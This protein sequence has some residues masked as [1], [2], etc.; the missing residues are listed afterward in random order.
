MEGI[1]M[2]TNK[3]LIIKFQ[4]GRT[5]DRSAWYTILEDHARKVLAEMLSTR[6]CNTIRITIKFR[7]TSLNNRGAAGTAQSHKFNKKTIGTKSKHFDICLLPSMTLWGC[8]NVLTHELAHVAQ[9]AT[10]RLT[11]VYHKTTRTQYHYWRPIDH[12]GASQKYPNWRTNV[13]KENGKKKFKTETLELPWADRPWEIEAMEMERKYEHIRKESFKSYKK[14]V[15][16]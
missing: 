2:T 1:I 14:E 3:R 5:I 8:L 13:T 9:Y 7:T 4:K 10:G 16:Q 6:L 15:K 12:T 11:Y